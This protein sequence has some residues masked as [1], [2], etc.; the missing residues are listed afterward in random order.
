[1]EIK[2]LIISAMVI[3]GQSTA[4]P[5]DSDY[6]QR[7]SEQELTLQHRNHPFEPREIYRLYTP[8]QSGQHLTLHYWPYNWEKLNWRVDG[9]L[10]VISANQFEGGHPLYSCFIAGGWDFFTSIQADC[11]GHHMSNWQGTGVIGFIYS[12]PVPGTTPLYRC[13]FFKKHPHHFDTFDINC[14]GAPGAQNDGILGHVIV[15]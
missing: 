2:A 11:E 8:D 13:Y 9:S 1:M 12:N 7:D 15:P 10:G 4:T 3:A 5:L 6:L 14:E